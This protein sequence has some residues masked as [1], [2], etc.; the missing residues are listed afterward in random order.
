MDTGATTLTS[1][2]QR[3]PTGERNCSTRRAWSTGLILELWAYWSRERRLRQAVRSLAVLD[4]LTL[5]GPG[6]HS[7][8]DIELTVRFCLA[9]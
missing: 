7:R 1:S 2:T 9:C 4:H 3:E 6:I 8:S 5:R